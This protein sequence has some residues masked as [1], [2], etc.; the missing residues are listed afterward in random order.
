[1]HITQ[2]FF[3]AKH[4]YT[5]VSYGLLATSA[6]RE[7]LVRLSFLSPLTFSRCLFAEIRA[8]YY[9]MV[10]MTNTSPF[11]EPLNFNNRSPTSLKRRT[12]YPFELLED[13]DF[14]R[15]ISRHFLVDLF[16]PSWESVRGNNRGFDFTSHGKTYSVRSSCLSRNIKSWTCSFFNS[17]ADDLLF[18][19]FRNLEKP[20]LEFCL[21]IPRNRFRDRNKITIS[22]D[23]GYHIQGYQEFRIDS[24]RYQKMLDFMTVVYDQDVPKIGEFFPRYY[25]KKARYYSFD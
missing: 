22:D 24:D 11:E 1:M 16:N 7:M 20:A 12:K 25:G 18:F 6:N 21:D 15:K 23:G 9:G 3:H 14:V 13:P 2:Y 17:K 19:G 5:R 8:N 4:L 10:K